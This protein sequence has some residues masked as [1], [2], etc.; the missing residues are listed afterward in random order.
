MLTLAI[1]TASEIKSIALFT[2]KAEQ[3]LGLMYK[4]SWKGNADETKKLLPAILSILRRSKK[5]FKDLKR[6]IVVRGPGQFSALRIGVTVANV[7]AN[8]LRI[9]LFS[10]GK[11]SKSCFNLKRESVVTPKYNKPPHITMPKD[12]A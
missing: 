10:V 5:T 2:K 6:I 11:L 7:L 8:T 9:P 12:Y 4:F 3:R 1:D